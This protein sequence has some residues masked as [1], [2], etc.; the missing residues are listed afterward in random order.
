M[1]HT[2]LRCPITNVV[3]VFILYH[4]TFY[5]I[6]LF[7]RAPFHLVR[8]SVLPC[9]WNTH[10]T[11]SFTRHYTI[12]ILICLKANSYIC[13]T[14]VE[15]ILAAGW[16]EVVDWGKG[17]ETGNGAAAGGCS[18]FC[19]CWWCWWWW[20]QLTGQR[21][22]HPKLQAITTISSSSSSATSSL[23]LFSR[24]FILIYFDHWW[25]VFNF[26]LVNVRFVRQ[27]RHLLSIVL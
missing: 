25:E 11:H 8:N 27:H 24:L 10:T 2:T 9:Y 3:N 17:W 5:P 1:W 16:W 7:G 13:T 19:C 18:T 23:Y 14:C 6:L 12:L 21:A 26:K 4:I 20:G 15:D 22:T